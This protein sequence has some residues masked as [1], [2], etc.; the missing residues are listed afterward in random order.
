MCLVPFVLTAKPVG[1]FVRL[2]FV[3]A[4]G[5]HEA[6]S[7]LIEETLSAMRAGW[8]AREWFRVRLKFKPLR[9]FGQE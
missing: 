9:P 5:L 1:Q 7:Y 6:S 4:V 3:S 2:K 8:T